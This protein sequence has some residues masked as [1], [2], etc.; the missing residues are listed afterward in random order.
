MF[1][2]LRAGG[3]GF[4]VIA[5]TNVNK[6]TKASAIHILHYACNLREE[7]IVFTTPNVFSGMNAGSALANQDRTSRHQLPAEPFHTQPLCLGIAA[8][9]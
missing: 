3:R 7:G 5:F 9:P 6:L 1:R 8:V 2:A 4:D